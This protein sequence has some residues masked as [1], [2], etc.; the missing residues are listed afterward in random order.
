METV[1]SHVVLSR[2]P[3]R[4]ELKL[5]LGSAW[6]KQN[7]RAVNEISRK[8][9]SLMGKYPLSL[10]LSLRSGIQISD[11]LCFNTHFHS[12]VYFFIL[13]N[14]RTIKGFQ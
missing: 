6:G 3:L 12:I 10:T 4:L 2:A 5:G 1:V 13:K 11:S 14:Q 8:I 7:S 9:Q